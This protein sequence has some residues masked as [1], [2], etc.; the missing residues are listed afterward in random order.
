MSV[1]PSLAGPGQWLR[2]LAAPAR[3]GSSRGYDETPVTSADSA[4]DDALPAWLVLLME[5][6]EARPDVFSRFAPPDEGGRESAVLLLFGPDPHGRDSILLIERARDMRSHPGHVA[7]PGGSVDPGDD[8][9]VATAMREAAEEVSLD[10]VGVRVLGT[11]PPVFF[12][13]SSFLV[14]PVI[15]WWQHPTPV[16]PGDP[17][18]VAQ[19]ILAPMEFLADPANRHTVHHPSGFLGPAWNIDDD[20]LLWGFTGGI[21]STVLDLAGLAR[22]WDTARTEPLPERL[23]RGRR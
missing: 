11:L 4:W 7:F 12:Q 3:S 9:A 15:A 20:V 6:F 14:T 10:P 1:Q 23:V 22:P 13:V 21:V 8:G 19:V 2:P 18:E 17:A 5:Q 16:S